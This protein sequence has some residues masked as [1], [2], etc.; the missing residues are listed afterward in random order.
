M[1][2]QR[3]SRAAG[4]YKSINNTR[5]TPTSVEQP[6]GTDGQ[7]VRRGYRD[8]QTD[9]QTVRRGYRDRQTDSKTWI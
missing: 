7:T 2:G 3:G 5:I 4:P 8:R 6:N 9:R 1:A